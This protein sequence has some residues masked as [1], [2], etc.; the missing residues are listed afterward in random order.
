MAT[1]V[2]RL[3]FLLGVEIEKKSHIQP[4][5][6]VTRILQVVSELGSLL[7]GITA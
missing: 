7:L 6:Y 1:L 2:D 5:F 3:R 4:P